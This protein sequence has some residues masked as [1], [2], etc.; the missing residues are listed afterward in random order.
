MKAQQ[1]AID[2][3]AYQM[4]ADIRR[5][6]EGGDLAAQHILGESSYC[7]LR[8]SPTDAAQAVAWW[9]RA[10]AGNVTA[11]QNDLGIITRKAREVLPL[12]L[13]R[14]LACMLRPLRK[15]TRARNTG[16]HIATIKVAAPHK[17]MQ[18]H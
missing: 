12:I 14:Q 11:A 2:K 7:D 18:W 8:G 17:T 13:Q 6:A 10:A 3:W 15:A 1:A 16:S 9:Q 4:L 5:A